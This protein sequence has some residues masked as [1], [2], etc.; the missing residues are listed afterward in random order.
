MR[1][2]PPSST[3]TH[4]LFPYP[5]LFPSPG[6]VAR[7]A[8]GPHH[9]GAGAGVGTQVDHRIARRQAA[10]YR[11]AVGNGVGCIDGKAKTLHGARQA[12]AEELV[13]I[14]DQQVARSSL[15]ERT[16]VTMRSPVGSQ[17]AR[18]QTQL[19]F[20]SSAS[21]SS[22]HPVRKTVFSMVTP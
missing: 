15:G 16:L 18:L 14:E 3:R 19:F 10:R 8:Q 5:A 1:S 22:S 12:I 9:L 21:T 7:L 20:F 17:Q 2:R 13:V 4:I 11:Q 6:S